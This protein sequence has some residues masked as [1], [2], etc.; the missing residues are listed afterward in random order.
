MLKGGCAAVSTRACIARDLVSVHRGLVSIARGL[1]SIKGGC[2]AVS[3]RACDAHT[4]T[5]TYTHTN[6]HTHTH[7]HTSTTLKGGCSEYVCVSLSLSVARTRALSLSLSLSL[8][9]YVCV[10]VCVCLVRHAA[11]SQHAVEGK[12]FVKQGSRHPSQRA[13]PQPRH[14]GVPIANVL[15]LSEEVRHTSARMVMHRTHLGGRVRKACS[16]LLRT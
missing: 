15:Q 16:A 14:A 1:V 12:R 5:H 3:A 7:T 13:Q 9:M 11:F 4:L 6:T 8:C 10:C 2:A